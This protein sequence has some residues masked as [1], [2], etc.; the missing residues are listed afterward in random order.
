[1]TNRLIKKYN[2]LSLFIA[3]YHVDFLLASTKKPHKRLTSS[4]YT[5][6]DELVRPEGF[7]PLKYLM[8]MR[9]LNISD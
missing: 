7:E 1:M 4:I 5:V 9:F 6:Y 8:N 2:I 3:F